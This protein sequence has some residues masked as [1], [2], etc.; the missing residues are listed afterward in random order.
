VRCALSD[1]DKLDNTTNN[2]MAR[3]LTWSSDEVRSFIEIWSDDYIRAQLSTT[4][5][6]SE[7]Y[8]VFSKQLRERGFNRT[9]AQCRDKAKKLRQQYVHVRDALKRTGS[10]GKEKDKCPWY[11]D[12][13]RILGTQPVV[14]PVDIVESSPTPPASND[15]STADVATASDTEVDGEFIIIIFCSC[16]QPLVTEVMV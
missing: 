8:A 11:D 14:D 12:I 1:E 5:K 10:S 6:N 13:D 15:A 4:H 16:Q 3:G 7:I 2:S 9:V